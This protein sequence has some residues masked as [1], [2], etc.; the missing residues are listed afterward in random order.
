MV[1]VRLFIYVVRHNEPLPVLKNFLKMLSQS[2]SLVSVA[3]DLFL[4]QE[5]FLGLFPID[6]SQQ[7][8]EDIFN[9]LSTTR[10]HHNY[11]RT[12]RTTA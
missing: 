2:P 8:P 9:G 10:Y 3:S 7:S 6:Q 4:L 5:P 12:L 1:T 11:Y